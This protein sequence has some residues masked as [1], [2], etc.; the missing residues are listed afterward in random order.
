MIPMSESSP[1]SA[2]FTASLSGDFTADAIASK[3]AKAEANMQLYVAAVRNMQVGLNIWQ[4]EETEEEE[5]SSDR[6]RLIATN[7]A[8]HALT[9]IL[10]TESIVGKTMAEVFPATVET[11]TPAIYAEVAR[12]GQPQ[13][14]GEISY[15]DSRVE[16]SIFSVKAFP[17]PGRCVGIAFENITERKR[18][19]QRHAE[20]EAALKS[21]NIALQHQKND[22]LT[23]N[24]MLTDTMATLEQRNQ[25]LDQFAYVT[26]HDLKAPLRAIANLATWIEEDIG[27]DLPAENREQFELLKSRVQRM[28]GL[29]NGLLEYSRIGRTHQSYERIDLSE[30]LAEIIDSISPLGKFTVE[31]APDMPVLEATKVPLVQIFSNLITN[32]IKHHDR[33]DGSVQ[34]G[35]R[36]LDRAY[37]FSV[38]DDGP[39]IDPAYHEKI[40]TIFQTLRARDQLESTGIGLSLVKKIV[41][42]EGGSVMVESEPGEGAIFRFTWPKSPNQGISFS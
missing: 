19:E 12:S 11:D 31:V 42:T 13:D 4:L 28:E 30:L 23:V 41:T 18:Y 17:L 34:I 6:L 21:A 2:N 39:G 10:E 36:E 27:A 32:A 35:V 9:G 7:P 22:L 15:E 26:S 1:Q 33:P 29:I 38:A 3:M 14:L 37:E 25:E 8:A 16:K 5:D 20:Q 40:F 24:M